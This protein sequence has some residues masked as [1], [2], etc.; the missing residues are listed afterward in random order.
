MR[1]GVHYL[2]TYLPEL[3]GSVPELYR[4]LTQ[5]IQ[6]AEALGFHDAWVTEHHYHPYGGLISHPPVFLASVAGVTSRIHLG[7]AINVLPLNHP[8]RNAEAYAMLDVISN[9]RLEFGVG[10]GATLA[11]F[12]SSRVDFGDSAQRLREHAEILVQ[13]WSDDPVSFKGELYEF[14]GVQ[15]LPKPLQRPHPPIWVGASRSDD[16]FR[17]AGENGFHLMTLPYAYEP[18]VLLHWLGVYHDALHEHGHD[19]AGREILGKLHVYVGESDAAARRDAE[20]YWMNYYH[21]LYARGSWSTKAPPTPED[22][23]A[24]VREGKA[25]VGDPARCIDAIRHWQETFGLTTF[26]GTFHFGGMPHEQALRSLRLFADKVMPAF[27]P[28]ATIA[29]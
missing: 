13:A 16:T 24:E 19:P 1:F 12:E 21:M 27:E 23:Q 5:Q 17:W 8:L 20:R 11:E 18:E 4:H 22:Y 2:N 26:S 15:V 28:A 25:V 14:E 3:D 29:S 9:G 7:V 10:R 6:E